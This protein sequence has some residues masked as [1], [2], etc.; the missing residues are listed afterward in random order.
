MSKPSQPS[1]SGRPS[2]NPRT[3]PTCHMCGA[4]VMDA[5][6]NIGQCTNKKCKAEHTVIEP[7]PNDDL[8]WHEYK[9]YY[10]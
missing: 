1:G 3:E 7:L 10:G 5:G 8:T 4:P 9:D 6:P 2:K